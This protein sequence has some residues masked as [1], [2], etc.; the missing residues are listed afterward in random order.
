MCIR[1]SVFLLSYLDPGCRDTTWLSSSG[2][3]FAQRL[4]AVMTR[5]LMTV[6]NTSSHC[7]GSYTPWKSD[8]W[9]ND[10]PAYP[11]TQGW[12]NMSMLLLYCR[13]SHLRFISD[14]NVIL[15]R[16][17]DVVDAELKIGTFRN[18][19]KTNASPSRGSVLRLGS[20]DN[21]HTLPTERWYIIQIL[22]DFYRWQ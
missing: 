17:G 3:V 16:V 19:H 8:R 2:I 13:G 7:S 6:I 11:L 20:R 14:D 5:G 9:C 4:S 21:R 22:K 10:V 1:W 18:V 15:H 12:S